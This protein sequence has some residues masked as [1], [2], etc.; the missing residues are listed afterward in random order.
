MTV[1]FIIMTGLQSPNH[2]YLLTLHRNP[3]PSLSSFW[4]N[5]SLQTMRTCWHYTGIHDS[6]FH[7]SDGAT[8]SKPCVRADTTQ[9]SMTVPFII[10]TGLLSPNHAYLLTLY[11]NPRQ[12]LSSFRRGYSLQ[13]MR[14][15]WHYT[16]I[17]DSPF[18]HSDGA[19]VSKPCVPA[20]TTQEST[21]VP[22]IILTGLKP[23]NHA[24]LL[25]LHR[26]PWLS[27]SS[28]WQ[29]Y[30][31]QTMRTC[32]HYTGIH[33]YPFHHSDGATVSKSCVPADTIQESMT[34]PFI[35]LTELQYPNNAYLMTLHR[36]PWL[37]L[38][39]FWRGYSLQTMRTCWHYTGIHDSPFHR[40]DGA[41][42]SKP[43]VRADTT[44][45]SMTVPFFNL[46]ELQSP[47][48][49]YQLTLHRNPLLFLSSFWRGYSLQ[50]MRTC[51]HYTGIHDCAFHHSDGATVS[52]PCVPA[53]TTQES[54]TV[55]FIILTGLQ[56]PNH[57]NLLTLH[58]NPRLSLSSFLRGY[59]LQT[60]RTCWHYIGI[61]DGPFHHSDGA[62]VSKPCVPAETT[63]ESMTVPFIILTELQSPNHAYLLTLHRNPWQS[64]SSFWRGY[65]FQTMRTC[66]HYT[67]IHD[68]PFHQSDWA[69]VSKPYVPA[70][71]TQESMTAPFIILT[72][73]QSPNHAYLLTLHRN[74]WPS[75]SSFWQV[76]S[77]QT[78]RTC[79]HYTGIHDIPFHHS[80]GATVSNPCVPADTTQE[81]MTVPFIIQTGLQSPNHAYL[82]TL[83]RNPWQFLS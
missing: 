64:L 31:L 27:L 83:H 51:W 3:W 25:T 72:G 68:C 40:S 59:S 1:P 80:D 8:V 67:G 17:H 79:W 28:F 60:M 55:P 78:M 66:W 41:T 53:D 37:S 69:T 57:A 58:R 63:Q 81:S 14:T 49:T 43:C 7:R 38:S 50:T 12:S 36:N 23:P 39:S 10:Q 6:P 26:N 75:L 74:P 73:L 9:E 52:K 5:Y 16:G 44:Q 45:E 47:N 70:D 18:H 62:T 76:Y 42:V 54:L 46:T 61:H 56:S 11:R 30:S 71:T 77:L 65:S 22:F 82:L 32:W 48:H 29:G 35:I 20:D 21:T 34:V 33:D 2:A 19:T 24:Y 4:R 13:T 15:C